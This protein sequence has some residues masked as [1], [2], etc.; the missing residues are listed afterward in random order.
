MKKQILAACL[1]AS[2]L[3]LTGCENNSSDPVEPTSS[4][5]PKTP[6]FKVEALTR[7]AWLR[8]NMP[9]NAFFYARVP[10]LWDLASYKEDTFKYAHGNEA[11]LTE[12]KKIRAATDVWFQKGEQDVATLMTFLNSQL[13]GPAELVAYGVENKPQL[14]ISA[15]VRFKTASELQAL[16]DVLQQKSV[17]RRVVEPMAEG[18][19]VVIVESMP[20]AYRWDQESGR[21]N[22]VATLEGATVTGLD[23][24]YAALTPNPASPMLSN[25]AQ[26]DDSHRGLYLWLDNQTAAPMYAPI[27]QS[28]AAMSAAAL[29]VSQ[30]QS[31]SASWGV[32][33]GK[34]RLKFEM[35]S[36]SHSMIRQF[37][38][39]A[40]NS[41][42]FKTAGTPNMM[43]SLSLPSYED[44]KRIEMMA[45]GLGN[46]EYQEQKQKVSELLGYPLDNWFKSIGPEVVFV[47]DQAGEYLA[48]RLR[49]QETFSQILNAT[50]TWSKAAYES[51]EFD[52]Q[53]IH[54]L[55]L[56]SMYNA[57][58]EE[59]N[60]EN[61]ISPLLKDVI[62]EIGTHV[63]W[64]QEGDFLIIADLPQ[65]LFDRQAL[66]SERSLEQWLV[67]EQ[68]QDLTS[69][70]LAFSGN[71]RNAPRRLYYLY[72]NS[73]QALGDLTNAKQDLFGL[74][75]ARQLHLA[76][77]G[78]YGL[79]LDSSPDK[80]AMEMVFESTPADIALAGDGVASIAMVGVLAAVALPAYQDYTKRAYF[81]GI[82]SES[83]VLRNRLETFR[84]ENGRYPNADEMDAFYIEGGLGYQYMEVEP[85]TGVILILLNGKSGEFYD[86]L[87]EI[88]PDYDGDY[89][90]WYCGGDIPEKLFP[91]QCR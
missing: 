23:A 10:S 5:Q 62:T 48:I 77:K 80:I 65:V 24:A 12:I 84:F 66:L 81:T 16:I 43:L 76:S 28:N 26:M 85:D 37:W 79:Q 31:L 51:R 64:Q 9:E 57:A 30:M 67:E 14:L 47:S 4:V 34:G 35:V 21:L 73:L 75:S 40:N 49:D 22:M 13:D 89:F 7:S 6:D 83:A 60:K 68:R 45:G 88:H 25:E 1:A 69:S 58:E 38:P 78:T 27:L 59:L 2:A 20:L 36:P 87:M 52:G 74:P 90:A 3:V 41:Y 91:A 32:S 86:E 70:S 39:A 33:N 8:E 54:H 19:G 82:Y 46:P 29:G 72:L 55:K 15:N 56:P 11:Y 18:A 42:P 61:D 50:K 63:Y 44:F 53:T 71:I 17:I